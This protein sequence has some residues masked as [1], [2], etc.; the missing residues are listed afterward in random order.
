MWLHEC[1]ISLQSWLQTMT[2]VITLVD[3]QKADEK[4]LRQLDV[5]EFFKLHKRNNEHILLWNG[6][7]NH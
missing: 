4:W 3:F 5:D 6:W 2:S 7:K 1:S